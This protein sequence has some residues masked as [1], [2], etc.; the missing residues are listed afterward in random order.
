MFQFA[1]VY[2][3][4]GNHDCWRVLVG[5]LWPRGAKKEAAKKP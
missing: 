1:R 5:R 3:P 2:E 4:P